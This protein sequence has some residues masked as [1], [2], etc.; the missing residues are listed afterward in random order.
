MTRGPVRDAPELLAW[1][2]GEE[3]SARVLSKMAY[4]AEPEGVLWLIRNAEM[5]RASSSLS[6][7]FGIV[8]VIA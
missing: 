4:R 2:E 8:A 1:D 5:S 6:W 7:K 3:V